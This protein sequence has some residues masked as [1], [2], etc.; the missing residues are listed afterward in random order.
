MSSGSLV[1]IQGFFL[2]LVWEEGRRVFFLLF[3]RQRLTYPAPA[4]SGG[5]SLL[6]GTAYPALRNMRWRAMTNSIQTR[7]SSA[8]VCKLGVFPK[9]NRERS[10]LH[11]KSTAWRS[12][13]LYREQETVIAP[14]LLARNRTGGFFFAWKGSPC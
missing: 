12:M 1:R 10:P 7:G 2:F 13:G 5:N 14:F 4:C 6:I 9:P 11:V 3:A 8:F